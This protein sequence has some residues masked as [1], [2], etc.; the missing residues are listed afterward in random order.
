MQFS[1]ERLAASTDRLAFCHQ[2]HVMPL[3]S[4][5]L[6]RHFWPGAETDR[7][8]LDLDYMTLRNLYATTIGPLED[9]FVLAL[10]HLSKDVQ[11]R[12]RNGQDNYIR[13][14]MT[15]DSYKARFEYDQMWYVFHLQRRGWDDIDPERWTMTLCFASDD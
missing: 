7:P 12:A 13:I 6:F 9:L 4:N 14:E 2:H 1:I 3:L 11:G 8:L 5:A 10:D 15:D